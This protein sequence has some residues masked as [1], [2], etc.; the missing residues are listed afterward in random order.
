MAVL[1][2]PFFSLSQRAT[3]AQEL[4]FALLQTGQALSDPFAVLAIK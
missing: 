1:A 2:V 4:S 3:R